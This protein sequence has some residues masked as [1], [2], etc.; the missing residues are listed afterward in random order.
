MRLNTKLVC[1][2]YVFIVI[3]IEINHFYSMNNNCCLKHR[4]RDRSSAQA[5]ARLSKALSL[6]N[7]RASHPPR[8]VSEKHI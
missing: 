6:Y 2:K 4:N 7:Q 5:Q 3:L 1:N 8:Q